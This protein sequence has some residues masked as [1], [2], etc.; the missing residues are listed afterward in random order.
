MSTS[1]R[2]YSSRGIANYLLDRAAATG[3]L[4][5]LQTIKLTYI[6]HGFSL[7]FYDDPLLK[8]EV[9][10]WKFGPVV[11]PVYAMLPPGPDKIPGPLGP[12]RP[13]FEPRDKLLVDVVFDRYRKFGGLYLS[14]LTH[15]SGTPWD[16]TWKRYG[17]NAVIP[18]GLIRDHYKR[19]I[20]GGSGTIGSIGL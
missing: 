16:L 9:E 11:R 20:E 15:R 6:A 8:E 19:V 10:A 4:D 5:A 17:Q 1:T 18:R 2:V 14:S 12:D 7:G 3:G 13:N